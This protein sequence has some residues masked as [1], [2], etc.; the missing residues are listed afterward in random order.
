MSLAALVGCAF[1]RARNRYA[2]LFCDRAHSIQKLDLVHLHH[3]LEHVAA[4]S[5]SKAVINLPDRM[6][7]ERRGLFVVEWTQPR[8]ILPGLFQ[9]DVFPYHADNVRLLLYT[10][11][12]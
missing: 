8:E 10:I 12:Q 11:R 4:R 7:G 2:A 1:P 6:H 5:T 9:T 3:K